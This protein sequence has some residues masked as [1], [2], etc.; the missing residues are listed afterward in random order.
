VCFIVDL[1][2]G[3]GCRFSHRAE[4]CC[5]TDTGVATPAVQRDV[6][7]IWK[8]SLVLT[9]VDENT[10]VKFVVI[11]MGL[12]SVN[13]LG[14]WIGP[15]TIASATLRAGEAF[16]GYLELSPSER[17]EGNGNP[18]LR[19]SANFQIVAQTEIPTLGSTAM[20]VNFLQE[21]QPSAPVM[22]DTEQALRNLPIGSR[23]EALQEQ[24]AVSAEDLGRGVGLLEDA[25][26]FWRSG[27]GRGSDVDLF[28]SSPD[29]ETFRGLGVDQL[30]TSSAASAS[31]SSRFFV[32]QSVFEFAPRNQ[33]LAFLHNMQQTSRKYPFPASPGRNYNVLA[34]GFDKD[35]PSAYR[36]VSRVLCRV[37]RLV[38]CRHV[39]S[40]Y[41]CLALRRRR[42]VLLVLC[43]VRGH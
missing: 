13:H 10:L 33:T 23:A 41:C 24:M 34:C 39:G 22:A 21:E 4:P 14:G 1:R 16:D 8:S 29:G 40:W 17:V 27:V 42:C 20:L 30:G 35:L 28:G 18:V 31:T 9:D 12:L 2:I 5:S 6:N 36:L 43:N 25:E 32:D 37:R 26:P 15:Q 19:L 7:P 11:D 3:V 38:D